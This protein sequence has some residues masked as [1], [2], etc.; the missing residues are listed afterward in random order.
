MGALQSTQLRELALCSR[1]E[2]QTGARKLLRHRYLPVRQPGPQQRAGQCPSLLTSWCLLSLSDPL[3]LKDPCPPPA[4]VASEG[5]GGA[6]TPMLITSFSA[7]QRMS[8][9]LRAA[10]SG[11]TMQGRRV[12]LPPRPAD[13]L[14]CLLSDPSTP[15]WTPCAPPPPLTISSVIWAPRPAT[16]CTRPGAVSKNKPCRFPLAFPAQSLE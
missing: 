13:L 7:H 9:R 16:S 5:V 10:A 2:M 11:Q 1:P 6:Q 14:P 15:A 8:A 3:L 4:D 12:S